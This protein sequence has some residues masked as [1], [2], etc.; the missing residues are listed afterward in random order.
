MLSM[1]SLNRDSIHCCVDNVTDLTKS[2]PTYSQ[3]ELT[4]NSLFYLPLQYDYRYSNIVID[5]AIE[6][7]SPF[8]YDI[9]FIGI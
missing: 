1:S 3:L 5:T 2:H 8:P 4:C 6:K 9:E 7:L